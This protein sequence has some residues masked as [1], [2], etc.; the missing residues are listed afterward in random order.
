MAFTEAGRLEQ[1][2]T[3]TKQRQA[4]EASRLRAEALKTQAK[5]AADEAAKKKKAILQESLRR[6]PI[7]SSLREL[8]SV[9]LKL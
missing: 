9:R 3:A 7:A 6:K 8:P 5:A 2:L 1:Q 4:K